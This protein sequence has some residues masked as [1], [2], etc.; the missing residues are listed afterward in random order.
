MRGGPAC[1]DPLHLCRVGLT[2]R[3]CV[4]R[5]DSGYTCTPRSLSLR[6]LFS[7]SPVRLYGCLGFRYEYGGGLPDL[8]ASEGGDLRARA[9]GVRPAGVARL[10]QLPPRRCR[11]PPVGGLVRGR[12]QPA[13][14]PG[15]RT[16][17]ER[18]RAAR[19]PARR[20]LRARL[21]R[22]RCAAD[23][24]PADGVG[25]R[26]LSPRLAAPPPLPV[27]PDG[28]LR[29]H[30]VLR[31]RLGPP[32]GGRPPSGLGR[33][34]GHRDRRLDAECIRGGRLFHPTPPGRGGPAPAGGRP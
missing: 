21:H 20:G 11:R 32:H 4:S 6:P 15:R 34:R 27:A 24:R 9:D 33:P 23:K 2:L 25:L 29:L 16:R 17:P 19:R 14:R 7:A 26:R 10:C 28:L 1:T 22:L 13:E 8:S 31:R 3:P 30:P 18:A 12:P 5:L